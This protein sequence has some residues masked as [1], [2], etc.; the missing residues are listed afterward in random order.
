MTGHCLGAAGA[1][2]ALACIMAVTKDIVIP[3][4]INHFTDDPEL[5]PA[6]SILLLTKHKE[7][8]LMLHSAIHFGFGG[9][10]AS[11]IVKNILL[12][13]IPVK[14]SVDCFIQQISINF[15]LIYLYIHFASF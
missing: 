14:K 1:L 8:P 12:N 5:D 6:N 15:G 11:V 4:T 10:N 9:H 7:N 2:E 3:P 13:Q